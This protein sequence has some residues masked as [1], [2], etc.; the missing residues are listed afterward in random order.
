MLYGGKNSNSLTYLTY[1]KSMK[2]ASSAAYMKLESLRPTEQAPMFHIDI[3]GIF[4]NPWME[5]NHGKYF[6]PKNLG[7][8]IR[9]CLVGTSYVTNQEPAPR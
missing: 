2:M 4:S 8:E 6:G 5:H 7:V 1:M 3:P 9:R